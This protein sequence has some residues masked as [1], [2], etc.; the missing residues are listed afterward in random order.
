MLEFQRTGNE[1]A[2]AELV[3][4][5]Q[6]PLINFFYRLLWNEQQAEDLSQEVFCRVFVHRQSYRAKA[7]FST[8]L[9]RIARNLWID[10]Y[11]A[12]G[13]MPRVSSLSAPAGKD[14]D[15]LID[16]LPA[17]KSMEIPSAQSDVAMRLKKA[18]DQLSEEQRLT[19]TLAKDQGM[20]YTDIAE[21]MQVPV[22][23]VRSRMHSAVRKLQKLL[24]DGTD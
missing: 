23:T 13:K 11:R 16:C 9:F 10:H 21:T 22:G 18:L 2:F 5:Y 14:G 17:P 15:E 12:Q 3:G 19:F 24:G 6:K 4:R 8:Y 1:D 7:K 20:K